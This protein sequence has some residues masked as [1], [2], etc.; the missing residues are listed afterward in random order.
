MTGSFVEDPSPV[1]VSLDAVRRSRGWFIALGVALMVLG[2]LSVAVPFVATLVSTMFLGW[3]LIF[4]GVVQGIHA[5]RAGAWQGFPWA[6]LSS[7]L[8]VVAG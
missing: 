5:V 1:F 4:S 7:V 3:L 8:G 6:V 2:F